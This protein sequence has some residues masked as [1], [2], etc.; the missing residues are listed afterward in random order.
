MSD[1]YKYGTIRYDGQKRVEFE[2]ILI[3]VNARRQALGKK[4]LT[5]SELIHFS[6]Q[7][8]NINKAVNQ[9]K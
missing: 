8:L 2:K 3:E 1:L 6:T 4:A 5:R 7:S 9:L